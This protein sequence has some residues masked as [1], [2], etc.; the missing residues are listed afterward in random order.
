M[1]CRSRRLVKSRLS[2]VGRFIGDLGFTVACKL[3]AE[4][5]EASQSC[6][7]TAPL[8]PTG[9]LLTR[10]LD[11]SSLIPWSVVVQLAVR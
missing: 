5:L 9:I 1:V 10:F 7:L 8:Q 2:S 6:M 11:G 4:S 3:S